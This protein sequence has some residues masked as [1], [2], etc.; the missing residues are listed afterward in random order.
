VFMYGVVIIGLTLHYWTDIRP[1]GKGG[2]FENTRGITNVINA[3]M[4]TL[5]I[6]ICKT[7]CVCVCFTRRCAE[8]QLNFERLLHPFRMNVTT[9]SS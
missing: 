6:A 4:C 5:M 7:V 3:T 2:E 9:H 1:V 8:L